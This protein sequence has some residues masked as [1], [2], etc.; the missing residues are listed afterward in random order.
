MGNRPHKRGRDGERYAALICILFVTGAPP[1]AIA[2]NCK[3]FPAGPERR[4]CAM[5]DHP[6]KFE[7]K[8]QH[9]KQLANERGFTKGGNDSRSY[10]NTKRDFVRSCMHGKRL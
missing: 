2:E 4:A 9:C 3:A 1:A 10:A 6:E 7:K 8:L 5:R